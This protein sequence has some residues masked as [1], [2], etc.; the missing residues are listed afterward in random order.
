MLH[1]NAPRPPVPQ[2][3]LRRRWG[4]GGGLGVSA[5]VATNVK[6]PRTSRGHPIPQAASDSRQ[7]FLER[8]YRCSIVLPDKLRRLAER[9]R[10]Y[11]VPF[12]Q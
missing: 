4:T 12:P 2:R 11:A 1:T 8:C 10:L 9:N 7:L 3:R 5:G 6:L